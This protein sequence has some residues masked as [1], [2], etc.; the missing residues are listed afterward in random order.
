MDNEKKERNGQNA[1]HL[2]KRME[3]E[4]FVFRFA[5]S[6]WRTDDILGDYFRNNKAVG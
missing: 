6:S 1:E 3:Q 4:Q 2:I 5:V